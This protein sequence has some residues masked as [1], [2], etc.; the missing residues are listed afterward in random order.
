MV[1][2]TDDLLQPPPRGI[3]SLLSLHV[4]P[5]QIRMLPDGAKHVKHP[6]CF[7]DTCGRARRWCHTPAGHW[8]TWKP[9]H[10]SRFPPAPMLNPRMLRSAPSTSAAGG[11][12][13]GA[14]CSLWRSWWACSGAAGGWEPSSGGI[15]S[16]RLWA[17]L[18][19][20]WLRACLRREP[21]QRSGAGSGRRPS[22]RRQA[23]GRDAFP[24]ATAAVHR[25]ACPALRPPAVATA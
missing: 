7:P 1:S 14:V 20:P 23:V 6:R 24:A 16:P 2:C 11:S 13:S 21:E 22:R 8:R 3:I 25:P 15:S 17:P 4:R 5:H 18:P 9:P 19:F 12:T 10:P